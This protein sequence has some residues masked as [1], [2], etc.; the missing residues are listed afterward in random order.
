MFERKS[1]KRLALILIGMALL[2]SVSIQGQQSKKSHPKPIPNDAK[3]V[4]WREPAD[5]A[6][7]DLFLG[8]GGEEMKPDLSN[9]T[10]IRD[11][12]RSY[13]T[14]YRV[15]DGAGKEWV[16]KLGKE[17]QPEAAATR[18]VWA[19]GYLTNITYLAPRVDIK[20]KGPFE[21]ALFKARPKGEKRLDI[22]WDWSRNPFVGTRELQGLKV[23]EA[24]IGNW[25]IQNHNNNV[26]LVSDEATGEKVAEY[27]NTDLGASF[28]KEG[29]FIGHTR[30]RPDQYVRSK[31]IKGVSHGI[32]NLD[33]KGKNQHWLNGIS[34]AHAKWRRK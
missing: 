7:R 28:A 5:I 10:F 14:R 11:E 19:D 31:F 1:L 25:D 27:I 18:L 29:R 15:H 9:V 24:L 3:S 2:L 30:N 23:L 4:L 6:S 21:N 8:P 17:A 16:V 32:V 22:R 33:F 13:S 20:G 34:V 26:L 12:T